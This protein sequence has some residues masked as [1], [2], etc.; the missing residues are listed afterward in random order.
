MAVSGGFPNLVALRRTRDRQGHFV[1]RGDELAVLLGGSSKVTL[2]LGEPGSGKTRLLE[3]AARASH[4][5]VVKVGCHQCVAAVP[6]EPLLTATS[7]LEVAGVQRV[8]WSRPTEAERPLAIRDALDRAASAS[9]LVVQIDD[10]QWADDASIEAIPYLADRLRDR[11]IRWH[12]AAR[13]GEDRSERLAVRLKQ[14]DVG[15]V[16]RLKELSM[17]EF[18]EFVAATSDRPM[19]DEKISELYSLSGGNPLYAEQLIVAAI[20]GEASQAAGVKLLLADRIGRLEGESL[21]VA[22]A[23]A[24]YA[25]AVVP[26]V[27]CEIVGMTCDAVAR[28]LVDL[29][30]RHLVKSS[31]A[32]VQFRHDL[33]RRECYAQ[34]PPEDLIALHARM[35]ETVHDVWRRSWHLDRASNGARAA[36]TL[37]D[38][39]LAMVDR[40][41]RIEAEAALS[42]ALGRAP[43]DWAEGVRLRAEAG[44]AAL[45]ALAGEV[46]TALERMRRFE[47][48]SSMLRPEARVE[49]RCRFAEAVFEGADDPSLASPYLESAITDAASSSPEA[50]PRLYALAGAVAD[51]LG[52]SHEAQR[53]LEL[54][55]ASCSLSTPTR[56]RLRLLSWLGVAHGRLGDPDRG[57]REVEEASELAASLGLSAEYAQCCVKCCY[58]CDLTG[59]R[60]GYEAWCR[61][62]LD[63]TGVKAPRVK[64][65]LRL[66]LATALKDRGALEEAL[67]VGGVAYEEAAN[68]T[69]AL[70]AQ[71]IGSLALTNAML[72]HFE[73]AERLVAELG[74][75]HAPE[76]WKRA[77][78]YVSGRVAE[79]SGDGEGALKRFTAASALDADRGPEAFDV[80][81]RVALARVL[82]RIG[83]HDSIPAAI[84]RLKETTL[85]RWP[86]VRSLL[87]EAEGYS[88]IAQRDCDGGVEKLLEAAA[89]S[90]ESFRSAELR[91]LAGLVVEDGEL[92]NVAVEVFDAMSAHAAAEVLRA[93]ARDL[94]FRPRP[95]PRSSLDVKSSELRIARL[96][97][98]GKTN[99]EIGAQLGLSAKTVEHY[100]SRMLS[101]YGVRFRAQLVAKV[102]FEEPACVE[103]SRKGR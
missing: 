100:V 15:D 18:R 76:R 48:S 59:D 26:G 94:G 24:A 102:G 65:I 27:L 71:A 63:C 47:A 5:R 4:A 103:P 55:L 69:A 14:V 80:R 93:K 56:D 28:V 82:C 77:I 89:A 81:I 16:I 73:V 84:D 52:D 42:G 19:D 38:H 44:L 31:S 74:H 11:A 33:I 87:D 86:L 79:L 50:L 95:R 6:Y 21:A 3:E 29:E 2:V 43:D 22:R 12:V 51:R 78:G 75:V 7:N 39:G 37:L 53:L 32:G 64:A 70:R 23:L 88:K 83:R 41:D 97:A 58:L 90:K 9:D 68:G 10:L 25:D 72:G 13:I 46:T 57:L 20:S 91:A 101:K 96:I 62:G 92:I 8:A 60:E 34:I 85:P 45:G 67:D 98:E 36:L 99:A 1:G 49:A 35:A 61:R 40:G 54:G 17:S 30:C 66:N